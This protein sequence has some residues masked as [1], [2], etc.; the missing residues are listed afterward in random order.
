MAGGGDVMDATGLAAAG[1]STG[2]STGLAFTVCAVLGK[3]GGVDAGRA[4]T[5]RSSK[6][7]KSVAP[8]RL[9][10]QGNLRAG[11]PNVC[12]PSVM[13]NSS[14]WMMAEITN[15]VLNRH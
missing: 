5:G 11:S 9:S 1:L 6:T 14:A 7:C 4:A 8:R 3:G 13:L 15:A 10:S 12:P 2:A